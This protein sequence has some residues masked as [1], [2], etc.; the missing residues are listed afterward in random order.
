MPIVPRRRKA[1]TL[2]ELVLAAAVTSV[3]G[4]AATGMAMALSQSWA[5]S[6]EYGQSLQSGRVLMLRLRRGVQ[7]AKLVV[8]ARDGDPV[9]WA[10]DANG[11]G[12]INRSE[13]VVYRHVPADRELRRSWV[14]FPD[15]ASPEVRACLDK[16]VALEDLATCDRVMRELDETGYRAEAVE[17]S[18]VQ[19]F[20]A[21]ASPACPWS[22]RVSFRLATGG[23]Q[24]VELYSGAALRADRIAEMRP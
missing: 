15:E 14:Q 22:K 16:A 8:C 3:I 21:A 2:A 19:V 20:Q 6:Q 13:I 10:R 23:R 11:D 18:D 5:H 4:L 24:P 1:F 12:E 7:R 17:G 9:L